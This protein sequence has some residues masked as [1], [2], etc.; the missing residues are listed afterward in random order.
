MGLG[1]L[2]KDAAAANRT[3][4][5]QERTW[6]KDQ[7]RKQVLEESKWLNRKDAGSVLTGIPRIH[8]QMEQF[9]QTTS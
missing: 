6:E 8:L 1:F 3:H 9:S 4:S 2:V 7:K 5:T